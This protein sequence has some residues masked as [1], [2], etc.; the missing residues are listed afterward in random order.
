MFGS[1]QGDAEVEAAASSFQNVKREEL[2]KDH[3]NVRDCRM[4]MIEVGVKQ[5]CPESSMKRTEAVSLSH[6]KVFTRLDRQFNLLY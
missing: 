5:V 6:S 4:R 2:A 3:A 1:A